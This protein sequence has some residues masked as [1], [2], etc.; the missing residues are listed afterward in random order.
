MKKNIEASKLGELVVDEFDQDESEF[1]T[2]LQKYEKFKFLS[3][4]VKMI[5][6]K[7]DLTFYDKK[8]LQKRSKKLVDFILKQISIK[9]SVILLLWF[10]LFDLIYLGP[11]LF[12]KIDKQF[13]DMYHKR[14]SNKKITN[15]NTLLFFSSSG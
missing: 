3:T 11:W 10:G 1:K 7:N 4:K 15:A 2:K 6:S 12:E 5:L 14:L 9:S 8:F 13:S